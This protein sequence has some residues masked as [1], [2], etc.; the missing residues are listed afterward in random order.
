ME[1]KVTK[2]HKSNQGDD[3]Y[4]NMPNCILPHSSQYIQRLPEDED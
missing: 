2:L 3:G 4:G 1:G